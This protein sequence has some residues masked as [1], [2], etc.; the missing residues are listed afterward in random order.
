MT[1]GELIVK[2]RAA[3]ALPDGYAHL[4]ADNLLLAFIDHPGVTEAWDSIV[5]SYGPTK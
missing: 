4:E 2:L 3:S 5:K 1:I